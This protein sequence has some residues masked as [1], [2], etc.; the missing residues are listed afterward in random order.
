MYEGEIEVDSKSN[1]IRQ[2]TVNQTRLKK[3]LPLSQKRN[4]TKDKPNYSSWG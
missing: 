3:L 1:G 4:P 2:S